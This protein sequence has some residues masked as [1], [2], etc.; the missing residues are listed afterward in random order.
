MGLFDSPTHLLIILAVLVVLF[1]SAKLPKAAKSMG[2]A[3]RIFKK[4]SAKLHE[5]DSAKAAEVPEWTPQQVAPPQPQ[6]AP[7]Q[8]APQQG[9]QDQMLALQ[10]QMDALQKQMAAPQPTV[11]Q[12]APATP[13]SATAPE[14][15]PTNQPG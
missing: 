7:Q 3:M 9:T 5:E 6:A 13:S 2:E 15:H 14:T 11:T 4:E 12:P 8:V 1:G 10:E